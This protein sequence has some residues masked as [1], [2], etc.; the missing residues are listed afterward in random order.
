M[1]TFVLGDHDK[2]ASWLLWNVAWESKSK[3]FSIHSLLKCALKSML[4]NYN[5]IL[6]GRNLARQSRAQ[7]IPI[8][9]IW[10][11]T[12]V[13]TLELGLKRFVGLI[14]EKWGGGGSP[15][16]KKAEDHRNLSNSIFL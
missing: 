13:K 15:G 5:D 4:A 9:V 1:I 3:T 6:K 10:K 12:M 11:V 2:T 16:K 7:E 14:H 8:R